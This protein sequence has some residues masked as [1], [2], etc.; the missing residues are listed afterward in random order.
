MATPATSQDIQQL[1]ETIRRCTEALILCRETTDSPKAVDRLYQ[2]RIRREEDDFYAK[3][4]EEPP[5]ETPGGEPDGAGG[6]QA[7]GADAEASAT[8]DRSSAG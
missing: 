5:V 6:E 8:T 1:R 4:K 7:A 2:K 3:T